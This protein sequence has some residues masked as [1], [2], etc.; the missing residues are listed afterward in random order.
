M[1]VKYY[2][3]QYISCAIIIVFGI[4]ATVV[5]FLK[6]NTSI[7]IKLLLCIGLKMIYSLSIVLSKFLMDHR[8]CSPYEVSFY[9]GAFVLI[10]NSILLAIFTNMPITDENGKLGKILTLTEYNGNKYISYY[11]KSIINFLINF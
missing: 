8:S 7:W 10:V 9:E 2:R 5:G 11:F 4:A 6:D 1:K 3:H